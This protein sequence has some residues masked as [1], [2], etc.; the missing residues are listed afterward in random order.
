MEEMQEALKGK[1]QLLLGASNCNLHTKNFYDAILQKCILITISEK[2]KKY[3]IFWRNEIK[4]GLNECQFK[5][6][7]LWN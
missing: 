3:V 5:M 1:E 7:K 2:T 4:F 6:L